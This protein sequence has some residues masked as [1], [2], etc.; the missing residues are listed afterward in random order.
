[1][2]LSLLTVTVRVRDGMRVCD[3]AS[4]DE[5]WDRVG[6][7]GECACDEFES[8]RTDSDQCDHAAAMII[9]M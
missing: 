6:D 9:M 2:W 7:S 4:D 3:T 1:M 5:C 8:D